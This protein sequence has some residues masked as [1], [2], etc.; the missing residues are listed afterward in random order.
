MDVW[1]NG[2]YDMV[3]SVSTSREGHLCCWGNLRSTGVETL[4]VGL[5]CTAPAH[6]V[7]EGPGE[8]LTYISEYSELQLSVSVDGNVV[9][10]VLSSESSLSSPEF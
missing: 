8:L 4:G 7:Y 10:L 3:P 2:S 5:R 1:S 9:L 6:T